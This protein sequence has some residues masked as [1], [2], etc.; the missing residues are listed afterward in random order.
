MNNNKDNSGEKLPAKQE[1]FHST[2][3]KKAERKLK[4]KLEGKNVLWYGLGMS[5]IVGL[6]VIIPTLMGLYIGIF[7]D[8]KIPTSYS[9]TLM[10]LLL[11]IILGC[12]NAWLWITR[13][14]RVG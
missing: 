14:S 4:A 2:V 7:L 12:F 13:K 6:L 1:E 5:G 8:K 10:G 11:G 9:F 3:K